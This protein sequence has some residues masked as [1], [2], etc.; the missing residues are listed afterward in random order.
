[1]LSSIRFDDGDSRALMSLYDGGA[2]KIMAQLNAHLATDLNPYTANSQGEGNSAANANQ[3]GAVARA[4]SMAS[5][6]THEPRAPLISKKKQGAS[7]DGKNKIMESTSTAATGTNEEIGGSKTDLQLEKTSFQ[8]LS[9]VYFEGLTIGGWVIK[10]GNVSALGKIMRRGYNAA[11]T[12]DLFGNNLLHLAAQCGTPEMIEILITA[13]PRIR[14]EQEN[15]FRRTAAMEGAI[16]SNF[17]ATKALLQ[18][19]RADA[20]RALEG[21]YMAWILAAARRRE[22]FEK[23]LN[24]GRTGDDDELYYSLAPDPN[25]LAFLQSTASNS[26]SIL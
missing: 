4:P 22:R 14:I 8:D 21:R 3:S 16:A 7:F 2:P 1:V 26:V 15:N 10:L 13:N 24:T 18:R 23:N 17:L 5:T 9:T 20:R 25:Y 6:A 11:A 12:A 19:Y